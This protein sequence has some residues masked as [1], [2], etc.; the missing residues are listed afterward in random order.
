LILSQKRT[1]IQPLGGRLCVQATSQR[2]TGWPATVISRRKA[3]F[4]PLTNLLKN[5]SYLS[6][7][8]E[9]KATL[10]TAVDVEVGNL[11]SSTQYWI[12]GELTMSHSHGVEA[13][14]TKATMVTCI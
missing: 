14:Y 12:K 8:N 9:G 10:N 11:K 4:F 7:V 13:L 5:F 6:V 1:Q 3:F 2:R